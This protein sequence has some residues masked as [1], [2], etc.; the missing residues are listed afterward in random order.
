MSEKPHEGETSQS[1]CETEGIARLGMSGR[2][3]ERQIGSDVMRAAS[4]SF[5]MDNC[6]GGDVWAPRP[7]RH[8]CCGKN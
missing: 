5:S 8:R 1:V 4:L 3:R 6:V 7:P 2:E